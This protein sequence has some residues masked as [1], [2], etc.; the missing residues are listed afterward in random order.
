M[1]KKLPKT[2]RYRAIMK[3]FAERL[4]KARLA[5]GYK[6][7]ASFAGV[8][9]L[10]EATYRKYERGA[11]EPSYDTLVRICELLDTTPNHLLPMA[12]G[13]GGKKDGGSDPRAVA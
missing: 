9:S 5:A 4:R 1:A 13:R 2:A 3:T 6:S 10:E 7:A 8:L 11:S 12:R